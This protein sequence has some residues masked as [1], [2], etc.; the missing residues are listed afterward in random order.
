LNKIAVLASVLGLA[1]GLGTAA[2]FSLLGAGCLFTIWLLFLVFP[3]VVVALLVL[4]EA[5]HALSAWLV[6]LRVF[7]ICVGHGRL[8]H[9]TQLGGVRLELR[10]R[11]DRG[12]TTVGHPN[13]RFVRL[14]QFLTVL[15]GPLTHG[16]LLTLALWFW[17]LLWVRRPVAPDA[18]SPAWWVGF[19]LVVDF[20]LGNAI[21]LL[22]N[23]FPCQYQ[24]GDH[25]QPSDG[26]QL[27]TLPFLTRAV[28]ENLHALYFL[29]EG[30]ARLLR[31]HYA[32]AKQW[33]ERGRAHYPHEVGN[34]LFLGY[35]LIKLRQWAPAR[36]HLLALRRRPDLPAAIGALVAD[37]M[38][39]A[40]LIESAAGPSGVGAAAPLLKEAEQYCEEALRAAG[41][42]PRQGQLSCQAT[43]GCVLIEQGRLQEGFAILVQV[44]ED[45]ED[46]HGRAFCTCYLALAAA[47]EGR[48]EESRRHLEIARQ[49]EPDC[50]ALARVA[51]ELAPGAV[52]SGGH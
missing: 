48:W 6:G 20:G 7:G 18:G 44:M 27:L 3:V 21:L 43:H 52:L 46:P 39:T 51:K 17:S 45:F 15:A 33:F 41:P 37:A 12:F 24:I 14:K 38:A 4:H 42:L 35:A 5:A 26:L 16:A 1:L 28:R 19:I 32:E 40:C 8:I 2:F 23:L 50:V 9:A 49:L 10:S 11:M 36:Q 29:Q 13:L 47:R 30:S 31:K 22:V 25:L 34:E